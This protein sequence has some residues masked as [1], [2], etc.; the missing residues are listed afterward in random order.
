MSRKLRFKLFREQPEWIK[1]AA[2]VKE[3]KDVF[4][5]LELERSRR[6]RC[7]DCLREPMASSDSPRIRA[8]RTLIMQ[9]NRH[10]FRIG[11]GREKRPRRRIDLSIISAGYNA[12]CAIEDACRPIFFLLRRTDTFAFL[13]VSANMSALSGASRG[14]DRNRAGKFA[15]HYD[16]S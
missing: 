6:L 2:I 7:V 15:F 11:R 3:K 8:S 1:K 9:S 16:E 10:H 5:V 13:E 4:G 12:S 14:M